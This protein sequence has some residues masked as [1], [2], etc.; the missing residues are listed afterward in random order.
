MLLQHNRGGSILKNRQDPDYF[1][2]ALDFLSRTH[3]HIQYVLYSCHRVD[4]GRFSTPI[5]IESILIVQVVLNQYVN[6]ILEKSDVVN[7][8][9]WFGESN[10]G[11]S[12]CHKMFMNS[13]TVHTK[14]DDSGASTAVNAPPPPITGFS[15]RGSTVQCKDGDV[16][17]GKAGYKLCG[18]LTTRFASSRPFL[19]C[20]SILT[21]P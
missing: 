4:P 7:I 1:L 14:A 19:F 11:I 17:G 15:T 16:S 12:T 2:I 8:K 18:R 20:L 13:N 9:N 6:S 3:S 10:P 5:I 21:N